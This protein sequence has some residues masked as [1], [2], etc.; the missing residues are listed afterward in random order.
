MK[1]LHGEDYKI[2]M[3]ILTGLK[4]YKGENAKELLDFVADMADLK[5]DFKVRIFQEF[6]H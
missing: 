2:F 4:I 3:N 5:A 6:S 1:D